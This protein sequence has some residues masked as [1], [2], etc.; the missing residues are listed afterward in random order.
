LGSRYSLGTKF[1]ILLSVVFVVGMVVTWGVVSWI[2][3]E[4]AQAEVASKAEIL[5]QAMNG[6]RQYTNDDVDRYLKGVQESRNTFLP[7][8]VP[9]FSARQVFERFRQAG[10]GQFFYKEASANPT[11]VKDDKSDTFED[12]VLGEFKRE[13]SLKTLS[14]Y[15]EDFGGER[16]F[17]TAVPLRLTDPSC[18]RCHD[19]P[20]AAP[21]A[22]VSVYGR[23]NGFGWKLGDVIATRI[24]YVPAGKVAGIARQSA[25][26]VTGLYAL[27]FGAGIAAIN[28]LLRRGVLRPI[29]SLAEATD[30]LSAGK[31]QSRGESGD[32]AFTQSTAAAALEK[33][34]ERGD[35]IGQLSGRFLLMAGEVEKREQGMRLAKSQAQARE[36]YF[37][38]L[39]ENASVAYLI[40]DDRYA[41]RY[42][43]PLVKKVLGV[44]PAAI[45]GKM[46]LHMVGPEQQRALYDSIEKAEKKEGTSEPCVF[47]RTGVGAE[48]YIEAV[49][50]NLLQQPSIKGLVVVRRDVTE[51]KKLEAMEKGGGTAGTKHEAVEVKRVE[52]KHIEESAL[53]IADRL[54]ALFPNLPV[55]QQQGIAMRLMAAGVAGTAGAQSGGAN[56]PVTSVV[57]LR[58]K[59]LM[60][61]TESVDAGRLMELTAMLTDFAVGLDTLVWGTWKTMAPQSEVRRSGAGS[62]VSLAGLRKTCG[63]YVSAE[64]TTPRGEVV[65]EL[66]RTRALLAALIASLGQV[67]QEF[68]RT[69]REKFS[70][71]E[72]EK[73]AGGGLMKDAKSWRAYKEMANEISPEKMEAEVLHGLAAYAEKLMRGK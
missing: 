20:E 25:L 61:P 58:T 40:L 5:L 71:L 44:E 39:I 48:R 4:Q 22:L 11:N 51:R 53:A 67:A 10:Y 16:R 7:E 32:M 52:E 54:M 69:Y 45:V 55:E 60:P 37:R 47:E 19:T 66:E 59:L 43:S 68:A 15:R 57:M 9:A 42:A 17:Y 38:A 34:K 36:A 3:R 72:V 64:G 1:N 62:A 21:P 24:V 13:S 27:V 56:L 73:R 65:H 50:T 49:V 28:L 14:G 31:D 26:L 41:V 12:G 8:T 63:S 29:H 33:S 30:A 6:V 18:L 35:E 23:N 70:P 46:M 2:A